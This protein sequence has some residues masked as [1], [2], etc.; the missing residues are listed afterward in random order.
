MLKRFSLFHLARQVSLEEKH[1]S[2]SL[3]SRHLLHELYLLFWG[4]FFLLSSLMLSY[5]SY[6]FEMRFVGKCKEHTDG[7]G[8]WDKA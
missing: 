5:A 8:V 2:R 4:L 3:L 7:I 1:S 6:E